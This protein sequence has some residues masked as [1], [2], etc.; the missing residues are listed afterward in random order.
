M[1]SPNLVNLKALRH[2]LETRRLDGLLATYP[3]NVFY[4]SGSPAAGAQLMLDYL[5]EEPG[6]ADLSA[7]AVL[8]DGENILV[9]PQ[10]EEAANREGA[11][12]KRMVFYEPYR[13]SP[14][15]AVAQA[16]TQAGIARGR[17]GI[18]TEYMT[19][20]YMQELERLMAHAQLVPCDE[21]FEWIRS[22]KTPREIA[23]LKEAGDLLDDATRE[24]FAS[25]RAG[26]S[27]WDIH[28]RVIDGA[29]R[30]GA[31]H[32]R[33]VLQAGVTN[34]I[35]FLPSGAKRLQPGDVIHTDHAAFLHGYPGHVS[36]LAVVGEPSYLQRKIY[37]NLLAGH[38][39]IMEFM[40]PGLTGREVF[41]FA[42]RVF[43]DLGCLWTFT[44]ILGHNLGL[45]YHERPML[46]EAETMRLEAT[47][48]VALEPRISREFHIQD[49][50]VLTESGAYLQTDTFDTR[51][52]FVIPA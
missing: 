18:E 9:C 30:R 28:R 15:D 4:Y 11:W 51:D 44:P 26:D 27:E 33:G 38:H 22:L 50:L 41:L 43:A 36:R 25:A 45:G 17:L 32:C 8:P 47:N 1:H 2:V 52:L 3:K 5:P 19:V 37:A 29:L 24:A 34:D 31:A 10:A 21:Q 39:R 48:V 12:A 6:R 14:M 13:Q 20:A 7:V 40:R 16:A 35:R 49:Q 23:M 46:T 42:R